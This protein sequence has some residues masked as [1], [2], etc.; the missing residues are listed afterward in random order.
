MIFTPSIV[1]RRAARK[2]PSLTSSTS[3]RAASSE[4]LA[5]ERGACRERKVSTSA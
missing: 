5:S 2:S 3:M 1:R 4:K